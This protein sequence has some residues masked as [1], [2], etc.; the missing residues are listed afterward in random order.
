MGK[1]DL[2]P[3]PADFHK[4]TEISMLLLYQ[5]KLRQSYQTKQTKII[6]HFQPISAYLSVN[7]K[8]HYSR[9]FRNKIKL[10]EIHG[11]LSQLN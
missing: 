9:F 2:S 8:W 11:L 4:S 6:K 5:C 3:A 1:H 10:V 7:L